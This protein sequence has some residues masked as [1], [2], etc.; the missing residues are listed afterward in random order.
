[1]D[2]LPEIPYLWIETALVGF[3]VLALAAIHLWRVLR[4]ELRPRTCVFCGES[5]P[6]D[7]HAH[8][9]EI[10]GLKALLSRR[11]PPTKAGETEAGRLIENSGK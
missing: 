3:V 2:H 1:M 10:C 11:K 8:H 6:S 9:L 4:S 7:D 5:I